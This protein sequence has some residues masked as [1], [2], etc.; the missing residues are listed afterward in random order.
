MSDTVFQRSDR[1]SALTRS[2]RNPAADR[3]DAV[4]WPVTDRWPEQSSIAASEVDE[5]D[6]RAESPERGMADL[7]DRL[8]EIETGGS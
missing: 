1:G 6:N 5:A 2:R 4:S 3:L 8:E 7:A